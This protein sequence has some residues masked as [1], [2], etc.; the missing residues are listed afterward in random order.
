ME[1]VQ[2]KMKEFSTFQLPLDKE[3]IEFV[4]ETAKANIKNNKDTLLMEIYKA[5]RRRHKKM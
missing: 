3:R 4:L 2:A 5:S 1:E